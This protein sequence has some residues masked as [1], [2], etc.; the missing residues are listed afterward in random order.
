MALLRRRK[1]ASPED[2]YQHCKR[3]N[4]CPEDVVNKIEHTTIADKILQYGSAGVF[5]G[6]LGIG[7]GKGP[8]GSGGYVPVGEGPGVRV[9]TRPQVPTGR[10][11]IPSLTVD[12]AAALDIT[13]LGPRI[14]PPRFPSVI[15]L[16]DFPPTID[17][18][19]SDIEVIAEV[20]PPDDLPPSFGTTVTTDGD[21]SAVLELSPHAPPVRT[22]TRTQYENPAFEIAVT[23]NSNTGET[24]ASDHIF[25]IGG[26]G[27]VVGG[28]LFELQTVSRPSASGPPEAET[29][30]GTSL[31]STREFG[32]STPARPV[33]ASRPFQIGRR[34]GT[35]VAVEDPAFLT[36]PGTLVTYDNPAFDA[37][38]TLTFDRDVDTLD[39]DI[40]ATAELAP[41]EAFRG[42]T[43]LSRP[44][45]SRGPDGLLRLSRVGSRSSIR[46]RS[47]TAIGPVTHYYMDI[48]PI[49]AARS[50]AEQP[51]LEVSTPDT[52]ELSVRGEHS[53]EAVT[54]TDSGGNIVE[55]AFE[56]VSLNEFELPAPYPDDELLDDQQPLLDN[57]TLSFTGS[58]G[59][60]AVQIPLPNLTI[61]RPGTVYPEVP[62]IEV[63]YPDIP[64]L[65]D[66]IPADTPLVII[67]VD[68][69]GPDF[70]LHPSLRRR[71]KRK[72]SYL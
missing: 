3:F 20:H 60:R 53:G 42:V 34:V 43:R 29:E 54:V 50:L 10:P 36:R 19:G 40:L 2:I 67:S 4:T 38:I 27:T 63:A 41:D 8:G 66:V 28:E 62:G 12:A 22:V 24:S 21:S 48:S 65:S 58:S 26:G 31:V 59:R 15:E 6:G 57:V 71:R 9:G 5:L 37:D 14:P 45:Y 30:F 44:T 51:L 17:L 49:Q 35:N 13:P 64:G 32:S 68:T 70:Y 55:S 46:T 56:E 11:Y 47:G 72:H 18:P 1:R 23:T 25:N 61:E 16:E 52:F 7:T 69:T 33:G 39:E